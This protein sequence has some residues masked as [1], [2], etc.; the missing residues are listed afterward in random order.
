MQESAAPTPPAFFLPLWA[1]ISI[2]CGMLAISAV[3]MWSEFYRFDWVMFLC[4]GLYEML[5]IPVQKDEARKA[6]LKNPRTIISIALL[7]GVI[8]GG[9]HTL[10]F[11]FK[12]HGF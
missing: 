6:Y 2:A 1:R 4:L 7:V 3:T 9:L 5:P 8:A 12:K 11:V 10:Y